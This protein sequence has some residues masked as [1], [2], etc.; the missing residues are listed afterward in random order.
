MPRK[1]ETRRE[2]RARA[3]PEPTYSD[4]PGDPWA[5]DHDVQRAEARDRVAKG[6]G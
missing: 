5:S 3:Q 2:Y 4:V 6:W 1:G